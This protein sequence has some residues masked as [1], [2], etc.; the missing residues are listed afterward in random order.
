MELAALADLTGPAA[1]NSAAAGSS[2]ASATIPRAV[3]VRT[4][5]ERPISSPSSAG[6]AGP[7]RGGG[8]PDLAARQGLHGVHRRSKARREG[9]AAHFTFLPT[10]LTASVLALG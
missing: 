1:T 8:A 9:V 3:R 6:S 4:M 7:A 2:A 10:A 5:D